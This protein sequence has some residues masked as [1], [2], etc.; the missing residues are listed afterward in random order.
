MD[1]V[2]LARP[3]AVLAAR[4]NANKLNAP[5]AQNHKVTRTNSRGAKTLRPPY[6]S[7]LS[8]LKNAVSRF[9]EFFPS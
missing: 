6:N 9:P 2:E 8:R 4:N 1:V 5:E 7:G 3:M